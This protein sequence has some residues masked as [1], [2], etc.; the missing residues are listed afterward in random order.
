MPAP[1]VPPLK[2]LPK[3]LP[4]QRVVVVPDRGLTP[5]HCGSERWGFPA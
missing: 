4:S 3:D 5:H 1:S 2:F